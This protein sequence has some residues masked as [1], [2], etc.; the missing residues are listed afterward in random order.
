[1]TPG[2]RVYDKAPHQLEA[3]E[4]GK[5]SHSGEWYAVPPETDLL[6]GLALHKVT[7]HEDGTITAS[8]SIEVSGSSSE[9]AV[10]YWHGYL[11]RGAWR[12]A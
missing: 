5:W 4:Y 2:R 10:N 3:G 1:M 12:K 11:E 6:A 8:P 9:R 7:E